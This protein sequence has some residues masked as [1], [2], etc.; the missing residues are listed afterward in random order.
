ML[1]KTFI[2]V[3]LFSGL[4][5]SSLASF[6]YMGVGV[7]PDMVK[8][9]EDAYVR[10][11]Q[12]GRMTLN[13]KN[14]SDLAGTGVFGSL[15]GGYGMKRMLNPK[16]NVYLAGEL[17]ATLSSLEHDGLNYEF[18]H[19]N[20]SQTQFKMKSSYGVSVIPGI[21][22]S[23]NGIFY[24]RLGYA[25]GQF[26]I[27]STDSSIGDTSKYLNG[28]GWGL[29][30]QQ[31][32]LEHLAVRVEFSETYYTRTHTFTLDRGSNT[33]KYTSFKPNRGQVE[34]GLFFSTCN[35]LA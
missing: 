5:T 18:V 23:N 21:Y 4:S 22:I 9:S 33:S 35:L 11:F 17:N 20:F 12:N 25:Y 32:L 30:L 28:F 29:G 34:F 14:R 26:K 15:F 27:S 7:G 2:T 6:Y 24:G 10:Q 19:Q 16:I 13:I 1:R 3:I 8:F 31:A